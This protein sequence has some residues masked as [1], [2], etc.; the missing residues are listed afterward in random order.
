MQQLGAGMVL[1]CSN[2][3][4]AALPEPE[5]AADDLR[6]M[7]ERAARRSLLVGYEALA[8]GKHTNRWR[9]AWDIVRRADPPRARPHPRQLPHPLPRRRPDGAR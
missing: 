4:A 2:V 6:E 9:Q 7:A 8:W 5:R 1:V 3:Q